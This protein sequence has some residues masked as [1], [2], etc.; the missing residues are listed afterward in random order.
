MREKGLTLALDSVI[1]PAASVLDVGCGNGLISSRLREL[2]PGR[3]VTG[4]DVVEREACVIPCRLYDGDTIPFDA[5]A[6]DYVLFVDVLHHTTLA[7]N[8]LLQAARIARRGVVIKDHYCE[9]RLDYYTLAIMDWIGN[10][11]YGV[12]L[13]HRYLAAAEWRA[14]FTR[15][16]LRQ[17]R[18]LERIGLYPRPFGAVFGRNLHFVTL[19][20]KLS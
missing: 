15:L 12:A 19:L 4:I 7:E 9:S 3:D 18:T 10:V 17:V 6:F 20:E 5:G 13:P 16:G 14:M 11:Q 8:L 2:S 1:P